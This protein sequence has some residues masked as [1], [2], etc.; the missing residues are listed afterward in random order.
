MSWVAALRPGESGK[1]LVVTVEDRT[2]GLQQRVDE[3]CAVVFE[4][5]LHAGQ[6]EGAA[7]VLQAYLQGGEAAL[8]HIDGWFTLVVWDSRVETLFAVRDPLGVQPLFYATSDGEFHVAPTLDALL[9][10]GARTPEPNAAAIAA[11]LLGR[12]HPPGETFYSGIRRLPPGHILTLDSGGVRV[13]RYWQPVRDEPP[14]ADGEAAERLEY[15]LRGAVS[16][17]I[18]PGPAGVFLSGGLD[19]ALVAA[20]TSDVCRERGQ[21]SPLALS[22]LFTGTEADESATQREVAGALG[23][24]QLAMAAD[25]AVEDGRVLGAAISLAAEASGP[26]ELL[27]PVYD[28]LAVAAKGR[29][30]EV[31]LSGAGGDE[32]LMPPA[33]YA[34]ERFRALDVPALMRLGRASVRYW[35]GATRRSVTRSLLFRS[36]LRPLIVSATAGLLGRV[37]PARL[38]SLRAAR[39]ART[40]PNWL[41]PDQSLRAAQIEQVVTERQLLEDVSLSYVREHAYDTSRRLGVASFAPLLE[42]DVVALLLNLA[43]TRLIDR[44]EAKR[45]A[46]EVLA[47]RLPQLAGSWPRT[48]YADCLWQE[49]LRREGV[50]AWSGLGGTPRLAEL[51][52]VEPELLGARIHSGQA[53]TDRK[54]AVQVC[55]TLILEMWISSRI[56]RRSAST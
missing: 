47:P 13:E 40:I 39:A 37:A 29:G 56:L 46:R 2:A 10:S 48:V 1:R 6:G 26:P 41:M 31:A 3:S 55:R 18:E 42:P 32:L 23:L 35:P 36:G 4:G 5:R 12:P 21:P 25:D 9:R 33:G 11:D 43:P 38:S 8:R 19:S 51:G 14:M 52:I 17:C 34:R 16:R 49:A 54:E 45:L 22:A 30:I 20:V 15:V 44:G 27:Q 50:G 7:A 24:E 53:A 28:R